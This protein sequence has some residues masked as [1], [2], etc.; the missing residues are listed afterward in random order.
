MKPTS[1]KILALACAAVALTGA[2]RADI[3]EITADVS[4][5]TRW[6]SDNVYVLPNTVYVLP[7]ARLTIEPGTIIR[8]ANDSITAGTNNPGCLAICR[9]A[10]LIGTGSVENPIIFTSVDDTLVPGGANTRPT[11]VGGNSYVALDYSTSGPTGNNAFSIARQYGGLVLL[12]RTPLAYDGNGA[13]ARY[14]YDDAANTF[15]GEAPTLP[16]GGS[17]P[18]AVN[19]TQCE[20]GDGSGFA[21]IEGLSVSPITLGFPFDPD[22]SGGVF[23]GSTS[24]QRG[25]YGGV[26]ED[27]DSGVIRFW[28][29]RYGGFPVAPGIELNG[30]TMGAVGRST[31]IEWIEVAQN[32]DD[33]F[34]WFGGYVNCRYLMGMFG[35]DDGIDT[36]QGFSGSIQHAFLHMGGGELFPRSGYA[37]ATADVTTA[38]KNTSQNVSERAF[39]WDG[40]EPN[41]SG[42][43]PRSKPWVFNATIIG[44]KGGVNSG[45]SRDGIRSR[46]GC[47][48]QVQ[49]ALFEDITSG[50][51]EQSDN[52]TSSPLA[53]NDT[54][55]L[56][57][58]YFNTGAVN[59]TATVDA[60]TDRFT[61]T[62]T[63]P[64]NGAPVEF[65][66]STTVPAGLVASQQ[67]FVVGSTAAAGGN[68]QVSATIGGSAVDL[69]DAGTSVA[70]STLGG[71]GNLA[72]TTIGLAGTERL[73]T[74]QIVSKGQLVKNGLNPTLIDEATSGTSIKARK[75]SRAAPARS[76]TT[77]FFSPVKHTGGMRDNNWLFGW[78]WTAAVDLLPTS[79]VAR[80]VLTLDVSTTNPKIS[81][82][83]D[84]TV[85]DA[86]D[87][88]E[89]V[90]ERS[91]DG[92][93]WAP[94]VAV[95]DGDS[96]DTNASAGQVTVTDSAFT[97]T[98]TPVHYRVIAQ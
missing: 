76:G 4:V 96:S 41:N 17:S 57:S 59:V 62:G 30:L 49:Y 48:G 19:G 97:Y 39:E 9:G 21:V 12:G 46:R 54:D 43:L 93:D 42:I 90:V 71:G 26:D 58:Y 50:L 1:S 31:T 16:T 34:E 44:N 27:D 92:R 79:N 6:S 84:T 47:S 3:I 81:F 36:D 18:E 53:Q 74:S 80:P 70:Y 60:G 32:S 63:A 85:T 14:N 38:G 64:A 77:G 68:F 89:Y 10:K 72:N 45:S 20:A 37:N 29:I 7:P 67:Y 35:G 24:F 28:S 15:T 25:V 66:G 69:T 52:S 2:A 56:D 5:D 73:F 98:G 95:Q 91:T 65:S 86:S 22:G 23:N 75:L 82:N 83:A 40:P 8:G 94:F 55:L 88:V 33:N 11:K 87:A 13:A 61:V 78:T 51:I